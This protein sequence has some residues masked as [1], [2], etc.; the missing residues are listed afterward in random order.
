MVFEICAQTNRNTY[1]Q[2]YEHSDCNTLHPYWKPIKVMTVSAEVYVGLLQ[3][4]Q[5]T[6]R[7]ISDGKQCAAT[8]TETLSY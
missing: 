4:G 8:V 2:S 6:S 7:T 5:F 1:K 3:R